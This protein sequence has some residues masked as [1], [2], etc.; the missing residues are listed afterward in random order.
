MVA[1]NFFGF[2]S[3]AEVAVHC[4]PYMCTQYAFFQATLIHMEGCCRNR[5]KTLKMEIWQNTFFLSVFDPLY[6]SAETQNWFSYPP[7]LLCCFLSSMLSF[8]TTYSQPSSCSILHSLRSP[9]GVGEGGNKAKWQVPGKG[10]YVRAGRQKCNVGGEHL[11]L[12][13]LKVSGF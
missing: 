11:C 4:W 10:N 1:F 6:I 5:Q 13:R 12:K 2:Y 3:P 8:W 7:P 9:S